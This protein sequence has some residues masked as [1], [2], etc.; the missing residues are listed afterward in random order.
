MT[1]FKKHFVQS[2]QDIYDKFVPNGVLTYSHSSRSGILSR[3][4]V[5]LCINGAA[6]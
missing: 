5:R 4:A 2:A 3:C 1:S 6:G